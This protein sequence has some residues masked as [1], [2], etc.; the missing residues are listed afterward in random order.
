ML[1]HPIKC[2]ADKTLGHK[3][4]MWIRQGISVTEKILRSTMDIPEVGWKGNKEMNSTRSEPY[5]TQAVQKLGLGL[6]LGLNPNPN[7]LTLTN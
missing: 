7:I 1:Y 3:A 2:N 5:A 6:G 4:L